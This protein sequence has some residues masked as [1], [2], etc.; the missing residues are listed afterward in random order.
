MSKKNV[1]GPQKNSEGANPKVTRKAKKKTAFY[2]VVF[3]ENKKD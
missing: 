2:R 1:I 3:Y